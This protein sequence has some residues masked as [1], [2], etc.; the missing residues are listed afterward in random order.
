MSN[1]SMY[2]DP[3]DFDFTQLVDVV[4]TTPNEPKPGMKLEEVT[5]DG[6]RVDDISDLADL[7]TADED[8]SETEKDINDDVSD[9]V[10]PEV[11]PDTITLFNDLPDDA[12][13]D[14]GGESMTKAQIKELK[15]AKE[16]FESQ[17]ELVSTAANSIDQI[18]QFIQRNHMAHALS[19][20]TNIQ[21]IQRKMNSGISATEYGEEARKLN[22]AFEAKAM[23]N[24]RIDEEMKLLNVERQEATRFRVNQVDHVLKN[25]VPQW[26]QIK[27]GLLK[28]LQEQGHDLGELEKVWNVKLAKALLNDYRYRKQKEQAGAK[29]LEA[30]K[31]KAPRSTSTPANA[32][33]QKSLDANEAKKAAL[34]KKARNGG[35]SRE[36]NAAMFNFLV[37]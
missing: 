17:K 32:Q 31:A 16:V 10:K 7:F 24:A 5:P 26:D 21:N 30:A 1:E 36:D 14:I 35:L 33:R 8:E 18:H 25:E 9:L 15:Q 34:L 2:F 22:Q 19:I 37:D 23:L 4:E 29:A 12:P 13:L 20:D 11:D 28:D 3:S 6:G 27:G